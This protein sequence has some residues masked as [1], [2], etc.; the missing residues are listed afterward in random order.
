MVWALCVILH[1][2]CMSVSGALQTLIVYSKPT[3]GTSMHA[4]QPQA[5]AF[6]GQAPHAQGLI[7]LPAHAD[8]WPDSVLSWPMRL[9][10]GQAASTVIA[11]SR[12]VTAC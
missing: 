1:P 3:Q 10:R 11:C 2:V 8:Q 7:C 9:S 6:D 12:P 4:F 5:V